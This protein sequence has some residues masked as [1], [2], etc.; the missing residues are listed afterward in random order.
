[1]LTKNVEVDEISRVLSSRTNIRIIE[2]LRSRRLASIEI[3]RIYKEK[4]G[5]IKNRETIYKAVEK[6][7]DTDILR[8][9]YNPDTKKL[10]YTIKNG[11]IILDLINNFVIFEEK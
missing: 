6:L 7:T 11:R 4:F 1:M 2:I 5:D 3:F 9:E 8:K 10:E